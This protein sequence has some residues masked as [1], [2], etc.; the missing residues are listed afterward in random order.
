MSSNYEIYRCGVCGNVVEVVHGGEGALFCC[1]R[2][3]TLFSERTV[4]VEHEP[5]TP[6]VEETARGVKVTVGV[7]ELHAMEK[8][9]HIQW[10]EVIAGPLLCRKYLKPGDKPE[11]EFDLENK[12]VI[13][14]A[15]CTQH[16][17]CLEKKPIE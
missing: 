7:S 14:R 10:I 2:M 5:Y 17:L 1:G 4:N 15:Y 13:A 16:G 6:H 12:T 9:H 11:A 8:D 3:M